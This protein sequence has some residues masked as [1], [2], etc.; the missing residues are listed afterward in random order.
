VICHTQP[1]RPCEDTYILHYLPQGDESSPR[2]SWGICAP[3][4]PEVLTAFQLMM[5]EHPPPIFLYKR[6]KYFCI[7]NI[8]EEGS[9][10]YVIGHPPPPNM[11]TL[12]F[13]PTPPRYPHARPSLNL[14]LAG[15]WATQTWVITSSSITQQR[16]TR[17]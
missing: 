3:A 15:I 1:C 14:V 4:L 8:L 16:S 11:D 9:F 6:S 17:A 13:C 2:G 5:A 10:D 12:S 7:C